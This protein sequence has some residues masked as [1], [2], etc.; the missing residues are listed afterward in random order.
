MAGLVGSEELDKMV[1]R[2][3]DPFRLIMFFITMVPTFLVFV[4]IC[5]HNVLLL[6]VAR[7]HYR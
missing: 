5:A 2:E 7:L 6:E 3:N 4:S 1:T